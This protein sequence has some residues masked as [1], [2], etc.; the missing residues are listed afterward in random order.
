MIFFGIPHQPATSEKKG[1]VGSTLSCDG[2]L[3]VSD[4]GISYL[5]EKPLGVKHPLTKCLSSTWNGSFRSSNA[6]ESFIFFTVHVIPTKPQTGDLGF[7]HK[8]LADRNPT[9]RSLKG[10]EWRSGFLLIFKL[11]TQQLGPMGFAG[12]FFCS[13][14]HSPLTGFW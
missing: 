3:V 6:W 1:H 7:C 10:L 2:S 11:K 13:C 9:S 14:S 8:S 4:F 5:K 12:V